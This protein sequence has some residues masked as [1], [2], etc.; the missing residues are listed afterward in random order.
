MLDKRIAPLAANINI[1]SN[2]VRVPSLSEEDQHYVRNICRDL[3]L[4]PYCPVKF[5]QPHHSRGYWISRVSEGGSTT[6][7]PEHWA[8]GKMSQII[9]V[10]LDEFR[11][12]NRISRCE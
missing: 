3:F 4:S 8:S 11:R 2:S 6:G 5:S 7:R 9:S 12:Y 1:L 10:F